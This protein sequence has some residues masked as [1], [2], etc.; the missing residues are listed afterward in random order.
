MNANK[1]ESLRNSMVLICLFGTERWQK[2]IASN[3]GLE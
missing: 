1:R 2:Q 3:L